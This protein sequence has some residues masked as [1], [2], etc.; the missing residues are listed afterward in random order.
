MTSPDRYA[1]ERWFLV[2]GLPAVVRR[3]ALLRRIWG[4]SAPAL[5]GVAVFAANSILVV[6]LSGKHT[7]DIDGRPTVAEGFLLALIVLVLPVAALVGWLVSRIERPLWRVVA[8]NVSV[9]VA[10]IG[11]VFGGPSPRIMVNLLLVGISIAVIVVAT[12]S[13]VGS[14]AGWA[15]RDTMSNLALASGMFVRALPVVLL[16]FLVFFNTYVW[17]MAAIVTR[18]RLWLAIGFL[19]AIAAAFLVSSTLERVRPILGETAAAPEDVDRLAGTPFEGIADEP[20]VDPLSRAERANV[21]FVVAASQVGQVLTVALATG[22]IFFVLGLIVLS[23]PLLAS[24]TRDSGRNDGHILGMTLP[25]PDPLIQTT[26]MLTAITF[27]YLAAKAVT[28]KEYR[29]QFL[30]PLLAELRLTLVA[31]DRYRSSRPGR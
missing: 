3:G 28:D 11:C 15:A 19:F 10:I 13:G 5:A 8:A 27:M 22:A 30:D 17:L 31:R 7:I 12:A 18:E 20:G 1:A 26:M 6:T 9:A 14:I 23:P 25:V 29:A 24:W 2:R 21:V 4:R 16:T